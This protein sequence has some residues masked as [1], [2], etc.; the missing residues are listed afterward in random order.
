MTPTYSLRLG[1]TC[2]IFPLIEGVMLD[3]DAQVNT[4]KTIL[5]FTLDIH[6]DCTKMVFQREYTVEFKV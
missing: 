6:K 4:L 3:N 1:E 2:F 5:S